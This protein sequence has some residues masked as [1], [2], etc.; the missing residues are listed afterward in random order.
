VTDVLLAH[1]RCDHSV[2]WTLRHHASIAIG[3]TELSRALG[4]PW[5][6]TPAP[7]L[8]VEKLEHWPACRHTGDGDERDIIFQ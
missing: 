8:H 2:N 3:T 6:E 4:V 5:G 1:S 7:K